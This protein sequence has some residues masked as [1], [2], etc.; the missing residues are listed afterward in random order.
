VI[1]GLLDGF[2]WEVFGVFVTNGLERLTGG[3]ER[4]RKRFAGI[5]SHWDEVSP[6][7]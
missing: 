7:A 2:V 4:K 6:G 5:K 3:L 1:D